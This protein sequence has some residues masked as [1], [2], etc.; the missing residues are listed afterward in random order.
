MHFDALNNFSSMHFVDWKPL[1]VGN[2]LGK[3]SQNVCIA[4]S[5]KNQRNNY[6]NR[7]IMLQYQYNSGG[8]N[9]NQRRCS[10]AP[11]LGGGFAPTYHF[12]LNITF[13]N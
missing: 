5:T 10:P 3:G 9:L 11:I 13:L 4:F 8:T 6:K 7:H 1:K 2:Q 12:F